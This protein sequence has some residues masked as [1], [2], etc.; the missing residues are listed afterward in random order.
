L[1]KHLRYINDDEDNNDYLDDEEENDF[2]DEGQKAN[3][4]QTESKSFPRVT[5]FSVTSASSRTSQRRMSE[6]HLDDHA[7]EQ[8]REGI[9]AEVPAEM[10]L[11]VTEAKQALYDD[12]LDLEND[13]AKLEA[14]VASLYRKIAEEATITQRLRNNIQTFTFKSKHKRCG[15][16]GTWLEGQDT[17]VVQNGCG[18]VSI[19]RGTCV[20]EMC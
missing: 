1:W 20:S 16:C 19:P 2:M 14:L 5:R 12:F 4:N 17:W 3:E 18:A 11:K 8:S 10:N 9:K 15:Q 13:V 7:S 6:D